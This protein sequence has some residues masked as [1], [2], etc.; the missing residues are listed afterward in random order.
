MIEKKIEVDKNIA[1]F[2]DWRI[3]NTFPDKDKV[4]RNPRGGLE[5]D[6]TF[7]FSEDY[8]LLMEIV[9]KIESI[10]FNFHIHQARILVDRNDVGLTAG[11]ETPEIEVRS[12]MVDF[13][14]KRAV[15]EAISQFVVWYNKFQI[16]AS[17]TT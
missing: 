2:M 8:N 9:D 4:W 1:Y 3:D 14:K 7:K 13:D 12:S 10:G 6:T 15:Y 17:K 16:N 5:L 11:L